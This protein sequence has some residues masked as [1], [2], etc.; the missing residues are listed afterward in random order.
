MRTAIVLLALLLP[1]STSAADLVH[2]D[3]HGGERYTLSTTLADTTDPARG[4]LAILPKAEELCGDRY[5]HYGHYRFEAKAPSKATEEHGPES[6]RYTQDIECRD[7]PQESVETAS[8]PVPPAPSTPP[9][10]EDAALIRTRT[11]TYLQAK[12]A[13]DADAVYGML[14]K[15]IASCTP[16]DAWTLARSAFNAQA[17]PGAEPTVVRITWYDN[18]ENAPMQGRY[19]A[20][21]Y[22]VDY[23]SDA[24]SC[25]YV[26]WLL[27]ADGG[28][29]I[30]REEES[31]ATPDV[32]AGLSPEQRAT[33]RAQLQCRD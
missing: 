3:D 18:P 2:V 4:Y 25:G 27:Q 15:E 19:V 24:F 32:V 17:G 23:P 22:R 7:T 33:M 16:P 8:A 12:N 26:V 14:S 11:L 21:D 28:Y 30:V 20:A 29:L 13:A 9:T 10:D 1:V 5:P 6:L 31:Q